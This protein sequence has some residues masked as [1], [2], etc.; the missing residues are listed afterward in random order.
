M[1]SIL[2]NTR[3]P[4]AIIFI[5]YTQC[6]IVKISTFRACSTVDG[7]ISIFIVSCNTKTLYSPLAALWSMKSV[8]FLRVSHLIVTILLITL[9][10]DKSFIKVTNGWNTCNDVSNDS[11][12]MYTHTYVSIKMHRKIAKLNIG[13]MFSKYDITIHNELPKFK[14]LITVGS[15]LLKT[16]Q[17]KFRCFSLLVLVVIPFH[18]EWHYWRRMFQYGSEY[19]WSVFESWGLFLILPHLLISSDHVAVFFVWYDL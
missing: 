3:P 15:V 11:K 17:R 14:Y 12:F 7:T 19:H 2:F 13:N 16:S 4:D 18:Y 5:C 1:W 9:M 8:N 6:N 10:H